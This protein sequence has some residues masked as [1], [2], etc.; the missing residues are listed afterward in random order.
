MRI[1]DGL[2]LGVVLAMDGGP[3]LGHHAGREPQPE[4]EEMRHHRMQLE[5]AMRLAAVQ[6][7]GYGGDRHV[8]EAE[9]AEQ[10]A[11]PGKIE[12]AGENHLY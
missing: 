1:L 10:V 2:A 8:R 7:D 12:Q 5:R 3:L 6:V 11:P 4:A 9:T